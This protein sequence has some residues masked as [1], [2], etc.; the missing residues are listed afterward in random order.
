MTMSSRTALRRITSNASSSRDVKSAPAAAGVRIGSDRHV[1]DDAGENHR[2]QAAVEV[3]TFTGCSSLAI[4]RGLEPSARCS[5][6]M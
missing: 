6:A 4:A 5:V 3:G 2:V 1:P